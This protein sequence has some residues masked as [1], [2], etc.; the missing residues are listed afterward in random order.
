[1]YGIHLTRLSRVRLTKFSR[2]LPTQHT[3]A[4][5]TTRLHGIHLTELSLIRQL[6]SHCHARREISYSA[7]DFL[8]DMIFVHDISTMLSKFRIIAT[9]NEKY[10]HRD[11]SLSKRR[12]GHFRVPMSSESVLTR[13]D[14]GFT[15]RF[16]DR[17][18]DTDR[19]NPRQPTRSDDRSSL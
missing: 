18:N 13:N 14:T 2:A 8:S 16:I 3:A 7:A 1:M 19:E 17:R 6:Q 12:K 4:V 5:N 11:S 9:S 10:A 15:P